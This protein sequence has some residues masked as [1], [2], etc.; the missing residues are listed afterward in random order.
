MSY[1]TYDPTGCFLPEGPFED[2]AEAMEVCEQLIDCAD[3]NR[4]KS[5]MLVMAGPQKAPRGW[6][7]PGWTVFSR[8]ES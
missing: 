1:W 4:P 6:E 8:V 5:F 7:Q 3:F 2:P